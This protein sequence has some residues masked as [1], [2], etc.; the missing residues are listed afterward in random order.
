MTGTP[1]RLSPPE[2]LADTE[3]K[4]FIDLIASKKSTFFE[5]S[6][7]PLL[8]AYCR[9]IAKE[10]KT[11]ALLEAEGDI[12][13]GK[14]NPRLAVWAQTHK[15]LATLAHKLRL[16]PQGRSPT[17]PGKSER[18][19]SYYERQDLEEGKAG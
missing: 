18:P 12:I 11:W 8:S 2:E 6:D 7:L 19:L 9:V 14:V 10:R 5:E 15:S 17:N 1:A 4:I 3:Q 13:D 16:S